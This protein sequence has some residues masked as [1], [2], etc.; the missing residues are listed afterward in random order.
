[1]KAR[2]RNFIILCSL[3]SLAAQPSDAQVKRRQKP[4]PA[5]KQ[6]AL[7]V[8]DF[9]PSAA[10]LMVI[11]SVVVDKENFAK[12]IP[13]RKEYGQIGKYTDIFNSATQTSHT[14]SAFL[15]GF[16]D[17]CIYNKTVAKDSTLLFMAE[18]IGNEWKAGRAI[19]EF[20][21]DFKDVDYPY[22]MPD[23]VTLY[24]SAINKK[25]GFG[26]RDIFISR[27]NTETQTF[28]KPENLGLPYN[29]EFNDYM[30]VVDDIDSLGGS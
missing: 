5:Q 30:C 27:L 4:K 26:K 11:D 1:M 15:N 19:E 22:L 29:S 10:K 23:G 13:L 6:N 24:F 18:K 21:D 20:A 2:T 14:S 17:L 3:L 12:H 28:Y 8:A 16:D 25:N 7:A 9:Y